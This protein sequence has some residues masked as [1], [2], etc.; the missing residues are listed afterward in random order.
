MVD[1]VDRSADPQT[2]N[3]EV[4]IGIYEYPVAGGRINR[5]NLARFPGKVTFGDYS[6]D[7]YPL[8]S[9][10][11]YT[12]F[13]GGQGNHKVKAGVDDDT[14]WT[15]T[16]E[17]RYPDGATLLPLSESFG[18]SIGATSCYPVGD[19]PAASPA[20]YA[21]FGSQLRLWND[22]TQAFDVAGLGVLPAPPVE[23][24]VEFEGLFY[25][26]LGGAGFV[27]VTNANVITTS[28]AFTPLQFMIWDNKLA[29]LTTGGQLLIK[30]VGLAWSAVTND[31]TLPSGNLPRKLVNF[32]NSRGEPSLHIVTNRTVYAYDPDGGTLYQTRLEYPRHP[33]Q[34]R[35]AVNWRGDSMYVSVGT[36]IHGYNGSIITSMGP[37]G[38]YGLPAHLRGTIVDL[39]PEYNALLAMVQ[40]RATNDAVAV[41]DTFMIGAP[42]YQDQTTYAIN[43]L[44]YQPVYS[45]ILRWSNSQWHKVWE[46]ADASGFP[47]WMEVSEADDKYFLWW[48][49]GGV[50]Y[51]QEL[52]VS[53]QNPKQALLSGS[54][55]FMPSGELITGWFDADMVAFTKLASHI[56]INL[57]DVTSAGESGGTV[58]VQYQTELDP[59]WVTL[60]TASEPGM[61]VAGF[62]MIMRQVGDDFSRGLP[63]RRIRFKLAYTQTPGVETHSPLMS[64]MILKFSK[65]PT[66]QL[67]W[68]FPIDLTALPNDEYKGVP[69]S[70]LGKHL[71]DQLS[72]DAFFEF[73]IGDDVYRCRV[74]QTQG[75][76]RTG[77]DTR[78]VYQVNIVQIVLPAN[79]LLA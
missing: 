67:S 51:R 29:A 5:L 71:E 17:T 79:R 2:S 55:R 42:L 74:A 18:S 14:F 68:S 32:V 27:T 4:R 10:L 41:A 49:Y 66:S 45:S 1:T 33:D 11:I 53:F 3:G 72:S 16:L 60:G 15:A 40:G 47:T 43:N 54:I 65:V 77:Y 70:T 20:F 62:N 48:G 28:A 13:A 37:D 57:D 31:L 38:R 24:G 50:M 76:T 56:E 12:T 25:I 78:G 9:A 19:F 58:S 44:P 73:G 61:T 35:G 26:P 46:S 23:R 36:G 52:P 59:G 6:F 21:A 39:F 22:V 69:A 7:S 34:G 8:I 30:P 64:S 75:D 63:F